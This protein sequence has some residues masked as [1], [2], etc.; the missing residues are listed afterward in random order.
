VAAAQLCGDRLRFGVGCFR[1]RAIVKE[2]MK[3]RDPAQQ[4]GSCRAS[5]F[6]GEELIENAKALPCIGVAPHERVREPVSEC[7]SPSL[8]AM[9]GGDVE[10]D[11]CPPAGILPVR[12]IEIGNRQ[13][14]DGVEH[15]VQ[16]IGGPE[17]LH[18]GL[19]L[20]SDL[21]ELERWI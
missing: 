4:R 21:L 12:G 15:A 11:P 1:T 14:L 16:V 13:D 20:R 3:E 19:D 6:A 2:P 7:A 18:G 8:E 17:R 5:G 9:L 10:P